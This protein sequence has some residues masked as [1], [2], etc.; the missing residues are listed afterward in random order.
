MTTEVKF[1]ETLPDEMIEAYV[2]DGEARDAAGGYE[3]QG[4]GVIMIESIQGDY[5]NVV[6]LPLQKL[7]EL[8]DSTIH[9]EAFD[10][11]LLA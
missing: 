6:G 2:A 8:I 5:C 10:A 4:K 3:I 11:D 7:V 1:D 9:A